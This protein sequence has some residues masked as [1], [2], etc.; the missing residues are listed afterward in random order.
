MGHWLTVTSN[1]SGEQS[2]GDHNK[3]TSLPSHLAHRRQK[4]ADH[5]LGEDSVINKSNHIDVDF[6]DGPTKFLCKVGVEGRWLFSRYYKLPITF[7]FV[8]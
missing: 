7:H 3:P 8:I 1:G 4:S 5:I 6:Q 2:S